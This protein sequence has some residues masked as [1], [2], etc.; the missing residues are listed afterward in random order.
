MGATAGQGRRARNTILGDSLMSAAAPYTTDTIAERPNLREQLPEIEG[1]VW[2]AFM[3]ESPTA[4]R[5]WGR[6]FTELGDY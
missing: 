5:Y 1:Q 2:P 6:L 4:S 3:L